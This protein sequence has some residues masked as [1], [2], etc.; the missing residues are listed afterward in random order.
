M[1][2]KIQRPKDRLPW[3]GRL[4]GPL[5]PKEYAAWHFYVLQRKPTPTKPWPMKGRVKAEIHRGKWVAICPQCANG[6]VVHPEWPTAPCGECGA[7][8]RVTVPKEWAEIERLL[9]PRPVVNQG[10]LVGETLADLRRENR[11]HKIRVPRVRK[12]S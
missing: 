10:W 9:E 5:T 8:I 7:V 12:A 4:T 11:E 6:A 3:A 2:S 1:P